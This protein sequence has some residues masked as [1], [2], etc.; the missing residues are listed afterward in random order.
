MIGQGDN[1]RPG[2]HQSESRRLFG[3]DGDSPAATDR[4]R[5]TCYTTSI[6]NFTVEAATHLGALRQRT[7]RI[8]W[9]TLRPRHAAP[10]RIRSSAQFRAAASCLEPIRARRRRPHTYPPVGRLSGERPLEVWPGVYIGL[11]VQGSNDN[12]LCALTAK[13]VRRARF[14]RQRARRNGSKIADLDWLVQGFD[15]AK[16]V[17]ARP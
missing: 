13:R 6:A 17:R 2:G 16:R 3:L 8:G 15:Y 11:N 1:Q 5:T 4:L 14:A 7:G 12:T 10:T 9:G